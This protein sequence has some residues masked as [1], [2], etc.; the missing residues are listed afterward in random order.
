[1]LTGLLLNRK[2]I[3]FEMFKNVIFIDESYYEIHRI[4]P[5]FFWW[6]FHSVQIVNT[7]Y[8]NDFTKFYETFF[9]SC[10]SHIPL[11]KFLLFVLHVSLKWRI[12]HTG[13]QKHEGKKKTNEGEV[14]YN[15][16]L[17]EQYDE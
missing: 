6:M 1:M 10:P 7:N 3:H 16:L 14:M 17:M 2:I 15:A 8:T 4:I 13:T 9:C 12:Y 5:R 11:Q